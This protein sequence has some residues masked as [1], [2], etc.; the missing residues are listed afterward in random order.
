[1]ADEI[2]S[3]FEVESPEPDWNDRGA[4]VDYIVEQARPYAAASVP[5]NAAEV[6]LIAERAASRTT[7]MAAS[8][9]NHGLVSGP[10]SWR[11]SL[12]EITA[13]TLVIHGEEDPVFPHAHGQALAD[14]IPGA[15]LLTLSQTGHELPD[16]VLDVVVPAILTHTALTWQ[17]EADRLAALAL[18]AG[19]PTGW[20]NRLYDEASNGGVE[21]PWDRSEPNPM[22][23]AWVNAVGLD[24]AGRRAV[25]V[26]CGLGADA[27]LLASVGFT[28]TA[29][30]IS[31]AAVGIARSRR[32]DSPVDYRVANLLDLPDSLLGAFDLVVENYTVQALPLSLRSDATAGVR[33]LVAPG[34]TLLV[35]MVARDDADDVPAGPPWPLTRAE[36]DEFGAGALTQRRVEYLPEA[37][38]RDHWRAE[39]TRSA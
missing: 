27:E 7:D 39:F 11:K 28:T 2:R 17:Q 15:R 18:A 3:T 34:G 23:A 4:V 10:G 13:P 37:E 19:D 32:P 16:R 24:G 25:V 29:F 30:D 21:M 9:T 35:I 26:G 31:P 36:I 5:Y 14:E 12:A 8:M 33:S 22:L 38:G 1:M 6:R 20:F